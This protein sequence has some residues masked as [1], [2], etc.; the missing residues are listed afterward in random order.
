MLWQALDLPNEY[1]LCVLESDAPATTRAAIVSSG[2]RVVLEQDGVLVVAAS[3]GTF[4]YSGACFD[5]DDAQN[6]SPRAEAITVPSLP[7]LRGKLSAPSVGAAKVLE[8]G[9]GATNPL[10]VDALNSVV[11]STYVDNVAHLAD[12]FSRN[13][14]AGG[15][16][17]A[18]EW[19]AAQFESFGFA[20][21]RFAFDATMSRNVIAEIKGVGATEEVVVVGAH[22]DSRSTNTNDPDLRA[23]GADDNA[24]G[25]ANLLAFARLV[26]EN[27]LQFYYT[28][29]LV[30]F[31]GEEQGALFLPVIDCS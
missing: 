25:V 17:Q 19:I 27:N 23:P 8:W 26:Q 28:L 6:K 2:S 4:S 21:S 22:Y 31:S 18:E 13:S 11:E 12:Y 5:L 9:V 1:S 29:R 20:T 10:I 14:R 15:A 24:S 7:Y 16:K 3:E 30:A